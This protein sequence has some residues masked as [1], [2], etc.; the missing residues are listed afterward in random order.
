MALNL[1]S[2]DTTRIASLIQKSGT[3]TGTTQFPDI[4]ANAGWV[5]LF[6]PNG[7]SSAGVV[8]DPNTCFGLSA[9]RACVDR[10]ASDISKFP[11]IMEERTSQGAW[12][13]VKDHDLLTLLNRR[14]NR[15]YTA[16]ET[17]YLTVLNYLVLGDGI[18]WVI[19]NPDG[20][21]KA[22]IPQP[23][24]RPSM[25]KENARTGNIEYAATNY[26]FNGEKTSFPNEKGVRRNFVEDEVVHIRWMSTSGFRGSSIIQTN[27]EMFGLALAVQLLSANCFKNGAV[28]QFAIISPQKLG[29]TAVRQTQADFMAES[30]GVQKAGKPLVLGGGV[31]LMKLNMSLEEA[32]MPQTAA[33]LDAEICRI[34]CVPPAILSIPVEGSSESYRNLEQDLRAYVDGCL[35]SITT[36]FEEAMTDRAFPNPKDR[37][38]YRLRLDPSGLLR[39]D[40]ATRFA[41]YSSAIDSHI[42]QPNECR[43]EEGLAPIPGGD[44]FPDK[45]TNINLKNPEKNPAVQAAAAGSGQSGTNES[46]GE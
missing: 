4:G 45:A 23:M 11:W 7:F 28:F 16:Y 32:Q 19:Q 2:N 21:P 33:R 18:L 24:A 9:F 26:L 35:L 5:P 8:V 39:A 10:I 31:E 27:A 42:L 12:K 15:R 22:F 38:K 13:S 34:M 3:G 46:E 41:T 44:T 37:E 6:G 29:P 36:P 17:K 30:S 20:T 43:I 1:I 25:I 40:R 14:P